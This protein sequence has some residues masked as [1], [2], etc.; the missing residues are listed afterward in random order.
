MDKDIRYKAYDFAVKEGKEIVKSYFHDE[1]ILDLAF[2]PFSDRQVKRLENEPE[3]ELEFLVRDYI[4][5]IEDGIKAG[6]AKERNAY[7]KWMRDHL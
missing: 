3:D 5:G 6:L 7:F 4:D 2:E 1:D